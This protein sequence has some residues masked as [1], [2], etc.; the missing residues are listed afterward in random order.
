MW[1]LDMMKDEARLKTDMI[2]QLQ[3]SVEYLD[4]VLTSERREWI[5]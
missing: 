1:L 3:D 2:A 5:N 4:T